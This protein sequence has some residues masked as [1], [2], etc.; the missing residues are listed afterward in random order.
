MTLS[1]TAVA[2]F[3]VV[4]AVTAIVIFHLAT[5]EYSYSAVEGTNDKLN[6]VL[7]FGALS[8]LIDWSFPRSRFAAAKIAA[9]LAYGVLIE[10]VQYFL[11]T[12]EASSLD[13]LADGV[14]IAAYAIGIAMIGRV[15]LLRPVER[16]RQRLAKS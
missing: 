12:R 13:L 4:L 5:T 15:P 1:R 6:H 2:T 14:G 8:L 9:L 11:P 10:V 16:L 3:R 7:A